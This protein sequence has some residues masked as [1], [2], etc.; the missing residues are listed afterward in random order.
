MSGDGDILPGASV[1]LTDEYQAIKSRAF[2]LLLDRLEARGEA[3]ERLGRPELRRHIA[4]AV[5]TALAEMEA[6][7][8]VGERA[9]LADELVDEVVG[10][11]PLEPLL[12]DPTVDDIIVNG[13]RRIYVERGGRLARVPVRFR[14]DAHVLAV[15]QRIVG[16]IGR[17]VDESTPYC[18]ARLPDGSRVNIVVPPVALDGPAI[19]IRKQ[20][21]VMM[22]AIDLVRRNFAPREVI[23]YLARA[24]RARLNMLI[25]GGT[26]SG[27]TTLLNVMSSFIGHEE[28]LVTIEDAAEL[29]LRQEH[30]VRLES[31][32]QTSDGGQAVTL[33]DLVRNALRMRP[34]RII[35]GEVRGAEAI[36]MLQAMSTGHDGSMSTLH[37]NSPRD[38]LARLEMLLAFSGLPIEPIAVRRFVSSSINVIAEVR[39]GTDGVRRLVSVAE[40]AGVENDTYRMHE[41]F[42]WT[43]AAGGTARVNSST[44]LA[45][46]QSVRGLAE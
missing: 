4:L 10:F 32:P 9:R 7:L 39:R 3:V 35:L 25:I 22:G 37:A 29:Q 34:D 24:V 27:K 21:K 17:R 41:V 14:D 11:G 28:R 1:R 13:P 46:L 23:D 12:A 8:N 40:L 44:F 43:E 15:I 31:R 38:A 19:S 26:G 20:R 6:A 30:V 16:P 2:A 5:D 45:K 18:D 42:T 33:R 36:E